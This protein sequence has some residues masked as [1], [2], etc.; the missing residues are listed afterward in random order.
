[1]EGALHTFVTPICPI[2]LTG[3]YAY[4]GSHSA[5]FFEAG[6]ARQ[7]VMSAAIQPDFDRHESGSQ[8]M[9]EVLALKDAA[10]EGKDLVEMHIL[11]TEDKK[12][13]TK[14]AAYDESLRKH[15]VYHLTT[16]HRLPAK[17]EVDALSKTE[18]IALLESL[19]ADN[20]DVGSLQGKYVRLN[21]S[22]ST[23]E[24]VLSLEAFFTTYVYQLQN[25]FSTLEQLLPQGYIYTIDPPSFFVNA[26]G[27]A[28]VPN[29]LQILAFK[30]LLQTEQ[31]PNL[32]AIAF[33]DYADK[34]CIGLLQQAFATQPD[35]RIMKKE[36]LFQGVDKTYFPPAELTCSALVLH[37]NSDGFGQNI[38]TE[39][40]SSMDGVL[41]SISN[42]A[43]VLKRDR[44][45]LLDFIL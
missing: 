41:G 19:I 26:I 7:A 32:K 22:L 11:P 2:Y 30:F 43:C 38:E 39:R 42:A 5:S 6:K 25:E 33:N 23:V 18:A 8:V 20:A 44:E 12:D 29:R 17:A 35:V 28:E 16:D 3:D 24:N 36:T 1:M 4:R 10:C 37:N 31:F 14:R 40:M 13:D 21:N 9:M 27:D 15:M 34:E 45:D